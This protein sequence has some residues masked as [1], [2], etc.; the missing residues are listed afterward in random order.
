MSQVIQR[1]GRLEGSKETAQYFPTT[2]KKKQKTQGHVLV[3][4]GNEQNIANR[5]KSDKVQ[6]WNWDTG[7]VWHGL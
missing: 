7:P 6:S 3:A 2:N 4:H 5:G 1:W